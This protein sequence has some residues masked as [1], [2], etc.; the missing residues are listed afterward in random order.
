MKRSFIFLAVL[1]SIF[2]INLS[3]AFAA[4]Q[5]TQ[6]SALLKQGFEIRASYSEV[7]GSGFVVKYIILQKGASAYQCTTD[8][9]KFDNGYKCYGIVDWEESSAY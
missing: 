8:H 2:S 4:D 3:S 6:I 1:V 5:F 7:H 9:G